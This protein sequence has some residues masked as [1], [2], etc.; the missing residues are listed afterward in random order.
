ME[1]RTPKYIVTLEGATLHI[2]KT[3][4]SKLGKNIWAFASLPGN[5]EHLLTLKDGTLLTN[6]PGTCSKYCEGCAKDGCCYAWRDAKLHSNVNIKA[7]GENTL[8]LRAGLVFT[9]LD[10]MIEE[11]NTNP[12]KKSVSTLRINTS[13]EIENLQELEEWNNLAKKHPEVT[14]Y[15]YTKNFDA[16]GQFYDKYIDTEDNHVVNVSAW[17]GVERDFVEKY[18][19]AIHHYN[20]FEYDDSNKKDNDL[21]PEEIER[22]SHLPHCYAVTKEGKHRILPDGTDAT[23]SKCKLNCYSKTCHHTAVYAH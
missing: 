8:L 10:H 15:L 20:I 2:S 21:S 5:S 17:H 6:I 18:P 13:G 19:Q 4:N 1:N 9:Q 12:R 22:L 16:L 11:Q 14:M 3:G 23:C 7:W